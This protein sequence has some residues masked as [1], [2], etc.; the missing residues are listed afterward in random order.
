MFLLLS[1]KQIAFTFDCAEVTQLTPFCSMRGLLRFSVQVEVINSYDRIVRIETEI[2][3]NRKPKSLPVQI[4]KT[5]Q[6]KVNSLDGCCC[7]VHVHCP[8]LGLPGFLPYL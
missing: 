1:I 6:V 5:G 2:E 4:P 7:V 3:A 8:C